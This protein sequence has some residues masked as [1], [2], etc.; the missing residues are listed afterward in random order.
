MKGESMIEKLTPKEA[1]RAYC[2]GCLGMKQ[3]NHD[4]V[5]N[6]QG[7]KSLIGPCP[8][9]PYRLGKR[10]SVKVFRAFCIQCMGGSAD[11]VRDCSVEGCECYP[12]RMGKNPA[13]T[14]QGKSSEKMKMV[15]EQIGNSQI[16]TFRSEA[17]QRAVS[18][19]EG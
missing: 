2:T 1:I 10:P 9:F 12:Y 16:S 8:F 4:A 13:R 11:S 17:I 18:A 5:A 3:F 19:P 6:C 7:D 15:R 14:G